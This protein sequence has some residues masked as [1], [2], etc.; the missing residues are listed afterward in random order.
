M[1]N[2]IL[3]SIVFFGVTV[4]AERIE[5]RG[6]NF[7]GQACGIT[8]IVAHTAPQAQTIVIEAM[9]VGSKE[10]RRP[11]E[12][13]IQLKATGGIFTNY[14]WAGKKYTDYRAAAVT[15]VFEMAVVGSSLAQASNISTD[16]YLK[17]LL[18]S[19]DH[20]QMDCRF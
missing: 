11:K 13:L 17:G 19:S 14:D 16:Y 7:D 1:K 2:F 12:G 20:Q 4:Q 15:E 10:L 6:T 9:T 5:L 3:W 8:L 18:T